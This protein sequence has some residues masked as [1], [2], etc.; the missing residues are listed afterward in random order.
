MVRL[1]SSKTG[2]AVVS[3]RQIEIKHIEMKDKAQN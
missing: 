1:A 2:I 3:D